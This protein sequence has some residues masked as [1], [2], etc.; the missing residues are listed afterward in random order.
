MTETIDLTNPI[1]QDED[2][3]RAHLEALNRLK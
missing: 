1:Y 2:L 3:A